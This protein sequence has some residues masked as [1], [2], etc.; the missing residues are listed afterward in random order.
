MAGADQPGND[1]G[2]FQNGTKSGT[3]FDDTNGNGDTR[4]RR[5]RARGRRDPPVRHRRTRQRRPPA[6]QNTD[7][8]GN[9]SF[10]RAAWQL[11]GVR[12]GPDRVH[13]VVPDRIDAELD[14]LRRTAQR[15]WL[16]VTLTSGSTDSGNDFGNFQNG[17][18]SG[19][20]FDDLNANGDP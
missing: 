13:A 14:G 20:K 18:K 12:D 15:P 11:H 1:F 4:C 3:K 5:A 8:S 10:T 2:N 19:T 6:H 17:T 16:G 9:Y 7:A